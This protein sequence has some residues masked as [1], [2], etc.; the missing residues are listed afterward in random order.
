MKL[1]NILRSMKA[2]SSFLET[3][4]FYE[5]NLNIYNQMLLGRGYHFVPNQFEKDF[6]KAYPIIS[7]NCFI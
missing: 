7:K 4:T 2:F 5:K 6:V 3:N 1:K